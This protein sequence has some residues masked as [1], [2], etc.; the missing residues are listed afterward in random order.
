MEGRL[1][2]CTHCLETSN[3]ALTSFTRRS[4]LVPEGT[5]VADLATLEF[6]VLGPLEVARDGEPVEIP[7]RSSE[8]C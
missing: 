8:R 5:S 6:R 3:G 2:A 1:T 7:A 4:R